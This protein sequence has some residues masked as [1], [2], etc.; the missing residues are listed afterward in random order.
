MGV[1]VVPTKRVSALSTTL[2]R[3]LGILRDRAL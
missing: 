1:S 2:V 3:L